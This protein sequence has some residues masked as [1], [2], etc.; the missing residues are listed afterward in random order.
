VVSTTVLDIL[1]AAYARSLKNKPGTIATEATELLNLVTRLL[2]GWYAY[3]AT[4]NYTV[5]AGLVDVEA[6]AESGGPDQ[7]GWERPEDAEVVFRIERTGHTTGGSGAAQDEVVVV[8]YD[9]PHAEP[10]KGAVYR[11]GQ[12]YFPAG[13]AKDPTG[14]ELRIFFSRRPSDPATVDDTLDPQWIESYNDLLILDVAIYLAVK[15]GRADEAQQ[16]NAERT[17][18][19]QRFTNF[20]LHP[21]ANERRRFATQRRV[22]GTPITPT[23]AG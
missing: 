15:D 22:P 3:A 10:G 14:G 18:W 7:E 6:Q 11:I 19:M 5:F 20:L 13:N 4:V 1:V 17:D 12:V 16:L 9:D 21:E 23:Q 8:P 2:R